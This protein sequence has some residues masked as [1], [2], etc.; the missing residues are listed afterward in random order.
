[1]G[2]RKRIGGRC[3]NCSRI[4]PHILAALGIGLAAIKPWLDGQVGAVTFASCVMAAQ[5]VM[6]FAGQAAFKQR[7]HPNLST[8]TRV[9]ASISIA[10]GLSW[11][12]ALSSLYL[13]GNGDSQLIILAVGCGIIQSS[14]ARAFMAPAPML[15]NIALLMT[16]VSM[17][18]ALKGQWMMVPICCVYFLFQMT[19]LARLTDLYINE[20]KA[21]ADRE[22][23]LEQLADANARLKRANEQ[24]A[25]HALT[26]G[27]TG[28]ANRRCF[29]AT[30][31]AAFA[32]ATDAEPLSVVLLDIDHFKA[33]NDRHGHQAGDDCLRLVAR[34]IAETLA[35]T[36]YYAARYGGEEFALILPGADS[37]EAARLAET[38]RNAIETADTAE[39]RDIRQPISAS[40]GAATLTR[41][42]RAPADLVARADR[43]LYRAKQRGRNRVAVDERNDAD[44]AS[45]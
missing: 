17:A 34:V 26:D 5:L 16:M 30:L 19:Y 39:P 27:L 12:L 45:A 33:F 10:S 13:S 3:P 4:T 23:A 24:L 9:F 35:G 2:G 1:L 8:W 29:D 42:D 14:C 40:F 25:R 21:E 28:I 31:G 20:I 44:D 37:F 38:L 6:R 18:A 15:I 11:G 36:G 22:T 43:A 41:A 7:R 32:A